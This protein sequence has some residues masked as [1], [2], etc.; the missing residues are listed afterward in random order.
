ML[1]PERLAAEEAQ[2][3]RGGAA[4]RATQDFRR[5]RGTV[6]TAPES[7][8]S[9]RWSRRPASSRARSIVEA[10]RPSVSFA[11]HRSTIQRSGA[12]TWGLS[13]AIGSGSVFRIAASVSMAVFF[14]NACFPV[15]I[16]YSIEPNE[17]WSERK[18]RA[19]PL[20]CSGDM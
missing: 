9:E 12:G 7:D 18:S 8:A 15:A 6:D 13:A 10:Y 11:R 20:A 5:D 3:E 17:N 2:G 4:I 19:W 14:W 1:L 16:S